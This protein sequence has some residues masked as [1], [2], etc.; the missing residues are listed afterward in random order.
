MT[1]KE[2]EAFLNMEDDNFKKIDEL[3]KKFSHGGPREGAG[4]KEGAKIV[5]YSTTTI[6]VPDPM[7]KKIEKQVRDY[8]KSTLS[9]K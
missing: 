2:R 7:L 1:K 9:K 8:K 4:R 6:R 3:T 5:P